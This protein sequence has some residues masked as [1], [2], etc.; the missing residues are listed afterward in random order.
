M[1][2]PNPPKYVS[3]ENFYDQSK[4]PDVRTFQAA[5]VHWLDAPIEITGVYDARTQQVVEDY[6]VE[7]FDSVGI[8]IAVQRNKI[9]V[10]TENFTRMLELTLRDSQ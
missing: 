3:L 2:I 6:A 1:V 7:S 9:W 8:T 4:H 10:P 5:L